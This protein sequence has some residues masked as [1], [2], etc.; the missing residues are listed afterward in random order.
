[1]CKSRILLIV[2]LF[3]VSIVPISNASNVIYVDANG[4]NEPGSGTFDDPFRKI[5]F[6]LDAAF[7]GDIVE[8]RAGIYT[9]DPKNYN[10]APNGKSITI[11]SIDPNDPEVIANTI[12]DPNGAGR[13][14][15]F[16][17]G[18][19]ANCIVSGLTIRNGSTGGKGGGI[20]CFESSPTITNCIVSG[21]YSGTHGGGFFCQLSDLTIIGCVI[22][23]NSSA[24]DGGGIECWR[25]RP[26][27]I[28]CIISNNQATGGNGGG[29]DFFYG[30]NITLTNCTV[31]K[32][33]AAGYG[34]AL[35]GLASADV[36]V[37]N[38][39]LWANEAANGPQIALKSYFGTTSSVSV[40]YSN[41]QG[42]E[43]VIY[44]P[45]DGLIW[46]VGNIEADP[47]FASF[48]ANDDP[49]LWDFHLQ[50]AY[51]RWDENF[52][53]ADF[54]RDRIINL[55]DFAEL[56]RE[57]LKEGGNLPEDLNHNGKVDWADLQILTTYFLT[58]GYRDRWVFDALTSP[59]VDAGDP[60][61]DWAGEPWPNGKRINMGAYGGTNQASMNGNPADFNIDGAVDFVDFADFSSKWLA[62]GSYI[63]DLSN[64]GVAEFADVGI[65]VENWLWQENPADF[66]GDGEVNLLDYCLFANAWQT[67]NSGISLD[68]DNDV[69]YYDLAIFCRNWPW[70]EK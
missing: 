16:N 13:G 50:S 8:I 27:V 23:G 19:D 60:N 57:W 47:C 28:N 59:C 40:S 29:V 33:S 34:G 46:G 25:G 20:Y 9:A 36:T 58:T 22:S 4:P 44:D 55:L 26:K 14:F 56:A 1:M 3:C 68:N 18:E 2:I 38:S 43:A 17:S 24:N 41:V 30:S 10:L 39:I 49:N 5:Q 12:I 64:D 31:V 48:D 37:K 61:P 65:F 62:E 45:C 11:R 6:A 53:R 63:E 35:Y 15:Y 21:N 51:G 70:H 32:N 54:N 52:Y 67:N 66:N 42:G 7:D 69:D